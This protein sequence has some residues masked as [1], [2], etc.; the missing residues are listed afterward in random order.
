M[1]KERS[2]YHLYAKVSKTNAVWHDSRLEFPVGAFQPVVLAK[3]DIVWR[4][5]TRLYELCG[6][7]SRGEDR[8]TR[9]LLR[10]LYD[11]RLRMRIRR[12]TTTVSI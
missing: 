4:R 5:L 12:D 6:K 2:T 9:W 8:R 10:I 1:P 3:R 11:L 7:K